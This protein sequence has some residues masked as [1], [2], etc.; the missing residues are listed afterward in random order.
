MLEE[1]RKTMDEE[2]RMK[3]N[4]NPVVVQKLLDLIKSNKTNSKEELISTVKSL[5]LSEKELHNIYQNFN[6]I[7]KVLQRRDDTDSLPGNATVTKDV[8]KQPQIIPTAIATI[9]GDILSSSSSSIPILPP[10]PLAAPLP[11]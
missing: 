7:T 3:N 11:P 8:L 2:E 5:G 1:K 10:P 6:L 9:Q 4:I